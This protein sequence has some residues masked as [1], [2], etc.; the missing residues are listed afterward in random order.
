EDGIRDYKVTGVQTCAFRSGRYAARYAGRAEVVSQPLESVSGR[1]PGRADGR[2]VSEL[3]GR[4]NT[5][6]A[7]G[8]VASVAAHRGWR[9][10]GGQIGR[11][12]CRERGEMRVGAVA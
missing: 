2:H 6:G 5:A 12:S 1:R 3:S 7:F 10:R 11:A 9:R 8:R 4:R